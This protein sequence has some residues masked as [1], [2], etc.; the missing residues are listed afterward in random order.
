MNT[1]TIIIWS[2]IALVFLY[3]IGR[4]VARAHTDDVVKVPKYVPINNADFYSEQEVFDWV[5]YVTKTVGKQY[6]HQ[7]EWDETYALHDGLLCDL[8]KAVH[9]RTEE[10]RL[11][12]FRDLAKGYELNA[13]IVD[14]VH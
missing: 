14:A 3:F 9:T 2:V 4:F 1:Y 12:W 11:Q 10:E 8:R 13:S 6:L 5:V 7:M